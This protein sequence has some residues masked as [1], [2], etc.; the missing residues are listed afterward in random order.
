MSK[1]K[2]ICK[3]L[4]LPTE[5]TDEQIKTGIDNILKLENCVNA[6]QVNKNLI[7]NRHPDISALSQFQFPLSLVEIPDNFSI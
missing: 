5:A 1:R 6:K 7:S 2:Q 3:I 4:D